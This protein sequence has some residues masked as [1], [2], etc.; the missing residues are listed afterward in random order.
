[1]K[2][3][4]D[5][6]LSEDKTFLLEQE[7][8]ELEKTT[9]TMGMKS[10]RVLGMSCLSVSLLTIS[11]LGF[12]LLPRPIQIGYFLALITIG[13]VGIIMVFRISSKKMKENLSK[14]NE[15]MKE[16]VAQLNEKRERLKKLRQAN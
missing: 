3:G 15:Q 14:D 12:L 1:M 10:M 9:K 8:A 5:T 4:T 7:I 13:L 2:P 6:Q 16:M 11:A